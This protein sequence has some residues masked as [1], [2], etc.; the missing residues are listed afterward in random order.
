FKAWLEEQDRRFLAGLGIKSE[1]LRQRMH[2]AAARLDELDQL[3]QARLRP[4]HAARQRY[5]DYVFHN[6][7]ELNFILDPVITIHPDEVSMEAF[8]RDESS[9]ARLAAKYDLF[10]R[11]EAFECGTTNIDFTAKLHRELDRMRTYRNTR[12]EVQPSGF[13]VASDGDKVH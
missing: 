3:R 8:S 10:A 12:F 7:Y 1:E 13:S 9:Y 4:F 2:V 5:F 6:Q 11:I